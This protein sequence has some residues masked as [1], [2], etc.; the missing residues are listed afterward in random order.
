MK[1]VV[2]IFERKG[3]RTVSVGANTTVLEALKLMADQ[4]TGSVVVM[5]DDQYLGLV[6]ERDYSRKVVLKGKSS[7]ETRVSSIMTTDL[8]VVT[9]DST[10]EECMQLMSSRGVRYLPVFK[11]RQYVGIISIND[12]VRETI[13][14]Q[15]EMI[16]HLHS[17]IHSA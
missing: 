2:H 7:G 13:S 15:Q 6:T 12:V 8:P 3:R 1:K 14:S 16:D 9:E 5:E 17:F 11:G 10:L 4:N